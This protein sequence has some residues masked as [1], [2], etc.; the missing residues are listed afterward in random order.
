MLHLFGMETHYKF[1][2]SAVWS[3]FC[4]LSIHKG[5]GTHTSL[6]YAPRVFLD[7]FILAKQLAQIVTN[8][9]MQTVQTLNIFGWILNLHTATGGSSV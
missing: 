8:N 7:N 9:V 1:C 4:T 5:I 2:S 3:V 6:T